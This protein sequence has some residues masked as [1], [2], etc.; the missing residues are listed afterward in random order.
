[1][2]DEPTRG[3]DRARKRELSGLV[4]ELARAGSAVVIASHDVE[5]AADFAERVVLLGRGAVVADAGVDQIL[6]GG[7]YF[8]TEVA[9]VLDGAAVRVEDG[10]ALL[11]DDKLASEVEGSV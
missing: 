1:M 8:S 4:R 9:R 7:W 2:L 10:A 11:L 6:S 3:M 5:F